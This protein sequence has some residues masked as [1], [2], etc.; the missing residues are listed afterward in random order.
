MHFQKYAFL[1]ADVV[2]LR[3]GL[4]SCFKSLIG[5]QNINIG[6]K[7]EIDQT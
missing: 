5:L 2:W 4:H 1:S 3:H 7:W 6:P